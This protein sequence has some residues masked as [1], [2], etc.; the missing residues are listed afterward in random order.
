MNLSISTKISA[1]A[2]NASGL[3]SDVKVDWQV[4][5]NYIQFTYEDNTFY[6]LRSELSS[7]LREFDKFVSIGY[8]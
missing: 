8:R 2:D 5:S 4:G 7:L 3:R 1:T 6:V